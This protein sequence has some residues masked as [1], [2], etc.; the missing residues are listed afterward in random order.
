ME[1]ATMTPYNYG[2]FTPLASGQNVVIHTS[3][4]TKETIDEYQKDLKDVFLD[5]IEI[6]QV[7]DAK[8]KF[9]FDNGMH[10]NLPASYALINI[11]VW[12]FIVKTDQTI[13][14]KHLFFNKTG[15]TNNY[16]KSY[17]DRYV[18]IPV[19]E[20]ESSDRMMIHD[21]NRTIYD[22]LRDL[23]F[24]DTFAWYFNNSINLEDFILMYYSCPGF[25]EILDRHNSNYYSQ[26]K[27]EDMNQEA[28]NDMNR[29]IGYIVD[30]KKYIGRDLCLSDAFRAK[31]GIKPKQAREMFV[32]IGI[33]PNGEGGIFPYVVNTSY[34][35]GG[36]NNAAFHILESLIARIAQI[37]S[38]KNTSRSGHF[39]RIMILNCADTKKYTI[40]YSNKIDPS[41]DC[42]TRNFLEYYVE[43]IKALKKI[44]DRWYRL[45]PMGMEKRLSN[46]YNVV[47]DNKDLIG[48]TIFLRSPIKCLSAA[49]GRGIC[50]KCLGELYNITPATNIGIYSVTN[51]TERLTQ[52]M[53]SAKH[54]LEAKINNAC[55]DTTYMTAEDL[56]KFILID[57]ASIY[58]NP[59]M[60]DM[61]KW[62][63]VI[64][65]DDIQ[66]ELVTSSSDGDDD[67]DCNI[68]DVVKYVN[69]FYL[70]K[71]GTNEVITVKTQN[72][73]N[74]E[75]SDWLNEYIELRE[76][77][78]DSDDIVIPVSMILEDN[79][80]LFNV[81]IHNDDMSERLE[82][83]IKVIDL[84]SNIDSYTAETFLKTL[85]N[86]LD[87][88]G[89][90]HIMAV[91][92]EI[93]VMN[94]IRDKDDILEMPDWSIPN[95][96]NYQILTLKKAV[97]THPSISIS[98]QSE[99]IAKML[100]NPLTFRKKKASPY[101]LMYMVQPQKFLKYDP[102]VKKDYDKMDEL[103][104][105]MG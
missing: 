47:D 66:E 93:I 39:S 19:R 37:L 59:N 49:N 69:V 104:K 63:M 101:D 50:R 65:A 4:I 22:S 78:D 29:L 41:Y 13:E 34:I 89:L 105:Y 42:G 61:K 12:G 76:L 84:K 10:V 81:G 62:S 85:S 11:I 58:L 83:V 8:V 28:L 23:K 35:S 70:K 51:L 102:V 6:K 25:Q 94:Q 68:D 7:Q 64:K 99:N 15:I 103:F 88:I 43:D 96:Q 14:P 24:V 92:L 27:P 71:S 26:F 30:A 17:I 18:I 77:N 48:K 95:N 55:L 82:S 87:D 97:M 72:V 44:A 79:S 5:Y 54:L 53:L 46:V 16:I 20:K 91:H 52:M 74:L 86:K 80:S 100:Y 31:E 73:D 60:P 21:L 98:M 36:A 2:V 45:H 57:E 1:T 67:D 3:D 38:K 56:A 33:K 75:L 32:N 90:D 9:I 40:P